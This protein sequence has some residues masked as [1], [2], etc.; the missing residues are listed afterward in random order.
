MGRS[1]AMDAFCQVNGR[2]DFIGRVAELE[3]NGS[4]IWRDALDMRAISERQKS[5]VIEDAQTEDK[6]RLPEP[7]LLLKL[8][9]GTIGDDYGLK[10]SRQTS[11]DIETTPA[12][13]NQLLELADKYE[14]TGVKRRILRDL[15]FT[16]TL[17]RENAMGVFAIAVQH[18]HPELA[19][20]AIRQFKCVGEATYFAKSTVN[21]IGAEAWWYL[22]TAA[23]DRGQASWKSLADSVAFP[24]S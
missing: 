21:E 4:P 19:R 12:L 18:Q 24:K 13:V 5:S 20:H 8:L 16:A 11:S 9:F 17:S 1:S 14:I 22:V 2:Y 7:I 6:L 10:S 3:F 23:T 15:W